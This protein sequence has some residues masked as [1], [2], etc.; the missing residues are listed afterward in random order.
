MRFIKNCKKA[1][2]FAELAKAKSV[3]KLSGAQG[4]E[5]GWVKDNELP[6]NFE[7][8]ALLLNVGNIAHQLMWMG[9]TIL[10]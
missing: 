8:A 2:D 9:L 5:L 4:G 7:D 6:K 1:A 3:D 10:F